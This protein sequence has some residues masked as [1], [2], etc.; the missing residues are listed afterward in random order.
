MVSPTEYE[1]FVKELHEKI[2][3]K[4]G[5]KDLNVVHN[6]RLEGKSKLK[7]QIDVYWKVEIAGVEQH[8]C[9]ECKY[10]KNQVKKSNVASFITV[11]NDIGNARG[12][13]VTTKGFQK[14][15][16]L[17][18]KEH[19][20]TLITANINTTRIPALLRLSI[21]QYENI[22]FYFEEMPSEEIQKF[23]LWLDQQDNVP[24]YN[25]KGNIIDDLSRLVDNNTHIEDGHYSRELTGSY[26]KMFDNYIEINKVEYDFKANYIDRLDLDGYSEVAEIVA[27]YINKEKEV[28]FPLNSYT[29]K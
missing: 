29:M 1:L 25:S 23:Q 11:L 9:I 15:A 19:G 10:W 4:D 24:V 13:F 14:G 5:F 22:H 18:A 26:L 3:E 16:E 20:V 27:T 28:I 21:P 7:H 12:I 6:I 17:L 2:L 8:F